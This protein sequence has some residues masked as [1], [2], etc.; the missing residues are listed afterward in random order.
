MRRTFIGIFALLLLVLSMLGCGGGG[1]ASG[2]G[3]GSAQISAFATD[4]I[5]DD[6]DHVWVKLY[7]LELVGDT[8]KFTVFEDA[9]GRDVDLKSLRDLTG[10][11][12]SFLD[13]ASVPA[14]TYKQVNVTLAK[15]V[16]LFPKGSTTGQTKQ[17]D[18]RFDSSEPGKSLLVMN[19]PGLIVA[20]KVDVVVDFDLATWILQ[21]NG[22]VNAFLKRHNGQG[23]GDEHRH[24]HEDFHGSISGLAG[25][26]PSFTFTLSRGNGRNL[27]VQTDAST[28]IYKRSGAD[29]P[30]L[31]NGQ[32][33]EVAGAFVAGVLI[34]SSIKIEDGSETEDPHKIKGTASNIDVP[35]GA[36]DVLIGRAFGFSPTQQTYRVTTS[37]TTRFLSDTGAVLTKDEFFGLLANGARVEAEGTAGDGGVFAAK[38]VK[39]ET[40]NESHEA[41]IKG[42]ITAMN[43]AGFTMTV[44]RWENVSLSGGESIAVTFAPNATFRLGRNTVTQA[45]F[46]AG[47]SVGTKVEVKGSLSGT[48]LT[49]IR[50]KDDN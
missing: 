47:I 18:D 15:D 36:F 48:T 17:F 6:F 35:A 13:T 7:K 22:R 16:V 40:E 26:A 34:A 45:Q 29:N 14:G 44:Q 46:L 41:E 24:V 42:P 50:A 30:Q 23:L 19:A 38:K 20:G 1:S 4:S 25:A 2:G 31:A 28:N 12:F 39:L 43:A 5:N 33:V 49:A 32:R 27:T 21:A 3:A 37:A 8:Q 11:K 9:A 10:P